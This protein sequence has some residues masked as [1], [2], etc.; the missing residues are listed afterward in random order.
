LFR[1]MKKYLEGQKF[2]TDDNSS[3]VSWFG[4]VVS[5]HLYMLPATVPRYG[6]S[7]MCR[8]RGTVC[9]KWVVL[10]CMRFV[11]KKSRSTLNNHRR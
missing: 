9:C 1:P 3:A 7:K 8:C 6:E 5:P 4:Y 11:Y 2:K 10:I